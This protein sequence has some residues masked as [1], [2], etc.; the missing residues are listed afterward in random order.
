LVPSLSS[1]RFTLVE[2]PTNQNHQVAPCDRP[3]NTEGSKNKRAGSIFIA[4]TIELADFL[5][6]VE[7]ACRKAGNITLIREEEI[8]AAAP[9]ETRT[10]REPLR[11]EAVSVEQGKRERWSVVPDGL[12]GLSF[13][14][15]TAAYFLLELDRG[16][17]QYRAAQAIIEASDAN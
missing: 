10:A 16:T 17:I 6:S 9:E 4:H 15:S 1:P 13:A 8:L 11:W 14:D 3:R 5:V 2:N 12:F 7:L